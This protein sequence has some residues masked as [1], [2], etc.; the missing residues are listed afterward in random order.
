MRTE[1]LRGF[2]CCDMRHPT[3]ASKLSPKPEG[4]LVSLD[5]I[6]LAVWHMIWL[7]LCGNW[8]LVGRAYA[9]QTAAPWD[10]IVSAVRENQQR[11][12]SGAFRIS[13]RLDR[14]SHPAYPF[15]GT[16]EGYCAFDFDQDVAR[17]ERFD[18]TIVIDNDQTTIAREGGRYVRTQDYSLHWLGDTN[19]NLF[20]RKPNSPP[21]VI[22]RRFDVRL[23]G[24]LTWYDFDH[25]VSVDAKMNLY[26]HVS[27]AVAARDSRFYDVTWAQK[28]S[29]VTSRVTFDSGSGYCPVKLSLSRSDA[30]PFEACETK[31][32][33]RASLW[34]PTFMYQELRHQSYVERRY[35]A[36]HW[37]QVNQ[38]INKD[39]FTLV[40]M[41]VPDNVTVM[42]YR[43]DPDRPVFVPRA[44]YL[45]SAAMPP[46]RWS[47]F[48]ITMI[49]L[50]LAVVLL[51]GAYWLYRTRRNRGGVV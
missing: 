38:P 34:V 41:N 1:T 18:P 12:R 15:E 11:L 36:F 32:Q 23:I 44:A 28:R 35:V 45:R 46:P 10:F 17:F 24:L 7:C 13:G 33:R 51:I 26:A 48:T 25:N 16:I 22:I 29:G 47:A 20:I 49:A 43:L 42:D 50:N 37:L 2:H 21:S 39:T 3:Q 5:S 4:G 30:D 8:L 19:R 40:G 6:A 27:P 9:E 31:W 14:S